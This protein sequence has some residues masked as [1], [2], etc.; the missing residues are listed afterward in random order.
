MTYTTALEIL[1]RHLGDRW[2]NDGL[3]N[4]SLKVGGRDSARAVEITI[5]DVPGFEVALI[6]GL[7]VAVGLYRFESWAGA[8]KPLFFPID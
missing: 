7:T 3:I 1:S 2:V 5:H 8:V 6:P 4:F